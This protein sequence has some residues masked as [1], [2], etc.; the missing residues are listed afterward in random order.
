[1]K[2]GNVKGREEA[3][4]WR[5]IY[6]LVSVG[7]KP[8]LVHIVEEYYFP[9]TK[10][11]PE[12]F[13]TCHESLAT[14]TPVKSQSPWCRFQLRSFF[15]KDGV[16]TSSTQSR[17]RRSTPCRRVKNLPASHQDSKGPALWDTTCASL[18][19]QYTRQQRLAHSLSLELILAL[20]LSKLM[21]NLKMWSISSLIGL[22]NFCG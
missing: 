19:N 12:L 13:L 15:I 10:F 4:S 21:L 5:V 3:N 20:T 9:I 18:K 16:S 17:Q 22:K 8:P 2:R 6:P 1:M 7:T 11:V 14:K